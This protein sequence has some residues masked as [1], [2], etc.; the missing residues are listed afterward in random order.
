[1]GYDDGDC[2]ATTDGVHV[3]AL[4]ELVLAR[5][6]LAKVHRCTACGDAVAYEASDEAERPPL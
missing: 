2:E 5:S 3:F 1:M 6:R 4:D